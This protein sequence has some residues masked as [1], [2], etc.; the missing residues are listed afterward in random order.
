MKNQKPI[1]QP[2]FS[3]FPQEIKDTSW[4][5]IDNSTDNG[6]SVKFLNNEDL[7][8]NYKFENF[9]EF[10]QCYVDD[11]LGKFDNVDIQIKDPVACATGSSSSME[12]DFCEDSRR[13]WEVCVS[14]AQVI[15]AFNGFK[16]DLLNNLINESGKNLQNIEGEAIEA[17]ADSQAYKKDPYAYYGVS[18]RDFL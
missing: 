4:L 1:P 9:K 2:Y 18:K 3:E 16:P 14:K 11:E 10:V 15:D 5:V 8:E 6:I 12:E 17:E 7:P 13:V